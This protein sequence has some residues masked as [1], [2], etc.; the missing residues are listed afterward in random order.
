ME[1]CCILLSA[2][3]AAAADLLPAP[4]FPFLK[5]ASFAPKHHLLSCGNDVHNAQQKCLT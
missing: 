3:P 1:K 2:A 4:T 5:R